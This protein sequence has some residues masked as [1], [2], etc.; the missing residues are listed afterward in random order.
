MSAA[1][2]QHSITS[3]LAK[4]LSQWSNGHLIGPAPIQT[5]RPITA[6]CS[7]EPTNEKKGGAA[8]RHI[9]FYLVTP[10]TGSHRCLLLTFLRLHN[11]LIYTPL[12]SLSHT[13]THGHTPTQNAQNETNLRL[14]I[15]T[16]PVN[17]A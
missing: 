12:H 2:V 5:R 9:V 6:L 10:S 14:I 8:V 3:A 11:C 17:S 7:G 1:Y 13:Q 15:Q 16:I 4:A